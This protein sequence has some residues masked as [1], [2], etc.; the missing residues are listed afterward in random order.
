[1]RTQPYPGAVG[2]GFHRPFVITLLAI[3]IIIGGVIV[4]VIGIAVA[5]FAGL[6]GFAVAGPAGAALGGAIGLVII[7]IGAICLVAGLGLWRLRGW[8]WWLATIVVGLSLVGSAAN[9]G[10]GAGLVV[11]ALIFVYLLLVKKHFNQ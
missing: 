7:I 9:N 11:T 4:I 6:L 5:L 8:A 3:L 2:Q 10:F 1:M